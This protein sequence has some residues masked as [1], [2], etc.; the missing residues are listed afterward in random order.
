VP[1]F[2]LLKRYSGL[3]AG[4]RLQMAGWAGW[5]SPS[6]SQ[7]TEHAAGELRNSSGSYQ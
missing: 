7:P 2:E 6:P 4:W 1:L 5:S 3:E